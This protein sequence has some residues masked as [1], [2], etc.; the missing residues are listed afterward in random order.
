MLNTSV[1]LK[2]LINTKK[3]IFTSAKTYKAFLR[4]K[5][6]LKIIGKNDNNKI[7]LKLML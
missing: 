6:Q 4:I 5:V 1:N 7:Q 2:F 3:L